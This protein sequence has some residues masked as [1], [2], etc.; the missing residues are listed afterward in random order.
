MQKNLCGPWQTIPLTAE[1]GGR[2]N[3]GEAFLV[4]RVGRFF[5]IG[6]AMLAVTA[7]SVAEADVKRIT[8]GSNRQG[9][10]FFLLASGFAKEFQQQLGIRATA[11]PHAGS[12]V[13]MSVVN[14]GEMTLGL[15]GSLDAGAAVRGKAPFKRKLKNIRAIAMV[16]TIPYGFMVKARSGIKTV[17]DL[18]GKKVVTQ[19]GPLVTLTKLNLAY[20]HSGGLS[21]RE[22]T[23]IRSGGVVDNI[24]K[25]VEGRADASAVALGMPAVRKAHALVPGGIRILP[26]G[27]VGTDSYLGREVPGA[28][29]LLQQPSRLRPFL[30]VPTRVAA[31]DAY[32]NAGKQ[33]SR[34]DAYKIIRVLHTRWVAMQKVYGPLRALNKDNIVPPTNP[35]PYH[36]GVVTYW[37]EVGLWTDAHETQQRKVLA[38]VQ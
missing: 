27:S 19:T 4:K 13:Y 15:N 14:K 20:L 6:T 11:Q 24:D 18:R 3:T 30:K 2:N 33:V 12:T 21:V 10:V 29:G 23:A 36:D 32:L 34:D 16:W 9:S 37:K 22:V 31:Y 35:H 28:R 5:A 25:V 38:T 17:A 26:L 1:G 8:I 7:A